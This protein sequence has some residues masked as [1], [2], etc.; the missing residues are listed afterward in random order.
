VLVGVVSWGDGCADS[1]RPGVY[2][3]IDRDHYL[4]WIRRNMAA[5]PTS[6]TAR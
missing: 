1:T 3:R 6:E 5:D 4:D 2:V